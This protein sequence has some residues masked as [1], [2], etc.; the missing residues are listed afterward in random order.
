VTVAALTALRAAQRLR[1]PWPYAE[2]DVARLRAGGWRPTPVNDVVFKIHQRCNLACSYCYVYNH[3]DQ[4]WRDRP[5]MMTPEVFTAAV[6][7]LA[8]HVRRHGLTS[9]RA[10][11]HGGEPM[12]L[13]AV[14]LGELA[15]EV[16]RTLPDTCAVEVGMQTNGVLLTTPAL[17]RLRDHGI[18][19]GVS[20]DGTEDDHD[21]HRVTHNGRGSFAAVS[22][23][24]AL[25]AAPEFRDNY[26]GLLCTVA[27]G[28]DP[29]ATYAQLLAFDPPVIDFLLPHANWQTPPDR[30][31]D[32][33]TAYGDWLSAVFQTWYR[34]S[35]PP[36]VRIFN[37]V[38]DLLLGG[39]SRSE[40]LGL[41]P[42]ALLVVES[43]GSIEQVDVLKSAYP[44]AC[45]TGLDVHH[46]ELDAAL[47]DPGVV[48][49]QIGV[50]ALADACLACPVHRIC[51]GGHYA[52][53][54]RLGSGFRE[55]SVYCADMA[56]FIE[57]ARQ[58][59]I[60][61]IQRLSEPCTDQ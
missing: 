18:K 38:L 52:H 59:V 12:L 20:V 23:A 46:D 51:G 31:D 36:A 24:L 35:D 60:N 61:D 50:A 33:P 45:A 11:L 54:Y 57:R 29:A 42:S 17:R 14:R 6:R 3:V 55:R 39:A 9:V 5:A 56:R 10:V 53:R 47:E 26:A 27:P 28:S 58:T 34:S 19:I 32:N 16:R 4:S 13:G 8:T 2:L 22:R 40:Q 7:R 30:P 1:A 48:A 44:D 49:R 43:D 15:D 25:L 41:S 21:R 37:D